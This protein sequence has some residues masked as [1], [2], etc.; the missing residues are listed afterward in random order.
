MKLDVE[1]FRRKRLG[2]SPGVSRVVSDSVSE[3]RGKRVNVLIPGSRG[4]VELIKIAG[5]PQ[6]HRPNLETRTKSKFMT[7]GRTDPSARFQN[8]ALSAA[9]EIDCHKTRRA[10]APTRAQMRETSAP[11]IRQLLDEWEQ[12]TGKIAPSRR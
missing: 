7:K 8:V 5:A 9:S 1:Y 11:E 12:R 2:I 3:P 4:P 6:Y 10:T